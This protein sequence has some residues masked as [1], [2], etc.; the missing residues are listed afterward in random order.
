MIPVHLVLLLVTT[1]TAAVTLVQWARG[2]QTLVVCHD[3]KS[4]GKTTAILVPEF[5]G[6]VVNVYMLLEVYVAFAQD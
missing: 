3:G 1:A 5:L 2:K 6:T 4:G